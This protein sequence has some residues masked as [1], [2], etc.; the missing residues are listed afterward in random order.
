MTG[1]ERLKVLIDWFEDDENVEPRAVDLGVWFHHDGCRT[2][3][4]VMGWA[5][6]GCKE[7]KDEGLRLNSD[8]EFH[9]EA[10]GQVYQ[11]WDALIRFF[12]LDFPSQ[13]AAM[14]GTPF[15]AKY[16]NYADIDHDYDKIGK[17]RICKELRA[18]YNQ[19]AERSQHDGS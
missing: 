15:S 11:D 4:C 9:C 10:T 8:I 7:L 1:L 6:Y 5:A 12:E 17:Y 19:L 3:G 2:T 18:F 13:V 14:H 16:A